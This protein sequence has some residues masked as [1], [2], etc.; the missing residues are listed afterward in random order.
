ME[1]GVVQKCCFLVLG[2]V[3]EM[4]KKPASVSI[5]IVTFNS[6]RYIGRCLDAILRQAYRPL[7]VIVVDNASLDGTRLV[8]AE[9]AGRIKLIQNERNVGF[10]AAQNQAIKAS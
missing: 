1:D 3:D 7:E 5:T 10:A 6:S 2:D 9:Y 8:L 4:S